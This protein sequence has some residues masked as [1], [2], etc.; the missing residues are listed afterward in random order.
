MNIL[1]SS[2]L[3]TALVLLFTFTLPITTANVA[4][5]HGDRLYGRSGSDQTTLSIAQS[6]S[7]T[8]QISPS[9]Q[10]FS[11]NA[12]NGTRTYVVDQLTSKEKS[13]DIAIYEGRGDNAAA[14][15]GTVQANLIKDQTY[16]AQTFNSTLDVFALGRTPAFIVKDSINGQASG[17]CYVQWQMADNQTR[18]LVRQCLALAAH[19]YDSVPEVTRNACTTVPSSSIWELQR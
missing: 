14:Y 8:T 4:H 19:K 7:P 18:R 15:I 9:Q 17:R 6:P 16:S 5:A 10:I 3:P 11:C 1:F 2:R 13:F 12:S